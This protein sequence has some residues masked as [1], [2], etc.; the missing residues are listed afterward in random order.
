MKKIYLLIFVFLF[1]FGASAQEIYQSIHSQELEYYNS[2]GITAEEYRIINQPADMS[3]LKSSKTCN[4]NKVVFGWHPYWS[5][6]L[7]DNYDWSLLSDMSFF[8]YEVN[9]STGNANTTHGWA[10]SPAVTTALANGVRV[11]LCVT[12]FS[13]HATFFGNPTSMQTL[14][15]N[16]IDLVQ[17]RGAHGV[18]IDFEGVSASLEPQFTAFLIDLCEQMHTAIP[19]SQV[20]VCT[21]AVDW[22]DVFNEAAIDPYIDY[23]TIMGYAYYYAGSGTAGPTAP[24]YTF[25]SFDYNLAKT[26]NYYTSE[27][28]SKEKLVLGLPYYGHEWN[29]TSSSVPSSTTSSVSSRTYKVVKDNASGNYS[30][31]QWDANSLTPYYVYY[32]SNWRQCFCDDEES[33]AYRYDLVNMMGIAGIGIWALAYDDGYTELWDLLREK[34]TDCATI[35]CSNTFYDLG[36]HNN[37][38]FNKSDY[39]FTI[40]PTGATQVTLEFPV[41]DIEAGS[42]AECNYD[43]LEIFDGPDIGSPSLGK[44]CNTTGNPGFITSTGSS[45]TLHFY[46]DGATVNAGFEGIWNCI[47]DNIL[48][49]TSVSAGEWQSD[50]FTATFIDEDNEAVDLSFYQVLDNDGTEWRAN[51]DFG[52]FNDNFTSSIHPEWTNLSGTWSISNG[53]LM[54]SDETLSNNNI[55]AEVNQ[56]AD[57]IYLY[58]WQMKLSGES[59][60]RRAGL[61]IYC[62]DPTLEQRGDAYMI[63]FRADQNK[64]QI[65]RSTGDDIV[66]HTDDVVTVNEDTWYDYKVMY[67]PATGELRAYQNDILVSYWTD[68]SPLTAGV[69]VSL[70]TGGCIA[71]YDDIKVYKSRSETEIISVGTDMEVRY[72]NVNQSSPACRIKTIVTDLSG[73]ISELGGT[74]VNIDF[75]A[76][77]AVTTVNDGPGGDIDITYVGNQLQANWTEADEPNSFITNY[78]YCIGL[79]AGT[80]EIVNWTNNGSSTTVTQTGLSLVSGTTYYFSIRATNIVDLTSEISSSDGILYIDPTDLTVADFTTS[81]TTVCAGEPIEFINLSQNA[82]GYQWNITGPQNENSTEESPSFVLSEGT[83]SVTLTAYGDVEDDDITKIIDVVINPIPVI[84]ESV[85]ASDFEICPGENTTLSYVGGSGDVFNWYTG[86]C[87]E[88]NV[89]QGNNLIVN[90]V[91]TT[92][93]YGRW[94]NSC[95]NSDCLNLT[96][97]ANSLPA[98]ATSVSISENTICFNQSVVLSYEG[99]S[100]E[101]FNWYT[102]DCGN[103]FVGTGNDLNLSPEASTVYYGRWENECGNSPCK[104]ISLTVNPLPVIPE[105]VEADITE[106]CEGQSAL[107][108]FTGGSGSSFKWYTGDC[109]DV[110]A[111]EGNEMTV[112]PTENVTYYGRWEN[113]CGNSDCMSVS[114]IVSPLPDEAESITASVTN[115]CNDESSVLSY[116]GGSGDVFNW[117]LEGC[118]VNLLGTGNDITVNPDQTT[119]YYGRWENACG[120]ADCQSIT[121]YYGH[122]PLAEFN[123]LETNL[124][125]PSAIA[126]FVNSSTNAE[127]YLWDFGDEATATDIEPWHQYLDVGVY[128][129]SLTVQNSVCGSNTYTLEDYIIVTDPTLVNTSNEDLIFIYPNPAAD[130]IEIVLAETNFR[131]EILDVLGQTVHQSE[132]TKVIDVSGLATGAYQVKIYLSDKSVTRKLVV[133]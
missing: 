128:T 52:F 61:Y 67:N 10:T 17:T 18:N 98:E 50:D 121:I 101:V 108:T 111:G 24:L 45:L 88:M 26:V 104:T 77:I 36:G 23:Y 11:N 76:P 129:V 21:Y 19:G 85:S 84:A 48:P 112:S 105:S 113:S 107:L 118:G 16:L 90:P 40:A 100:G 123:A 109:G 4:L 70:R 27:G 89:G 86:I 22:G 13:N 115:I 9:A 102:I 62:S 103:T 94:E 39:T 130:K 53:H 63:Y 34:F 35:P 93:Y 95:G 116:S 92:T 32:S 57:N 14:I 127:T 12:L 38:Y 31:R 72:E 133:K 56:G 28:A 2:L 15:T 60:N 81:S 29:T 75:T 55:Y 110:F 3:N 119:T 65:Y 83:Y 33:L 20:S 54:Q 96:I 47:E 71:E 59:T 43:Y 125:L 74:D 97:T 73:N 6:G 7:E 117:Y 49:T 78:E 79:S 44:F 126:Y 82:I 64:C 99:G 120:F 114:L 124:E 41:F 69:A 106:F 122:N 51:E 58:H 42:G 30:D 8:S 46:S 37:D 131:V 1:C 66:I 5:E 80:S 132:N 91:S 68:P 87:G 25:A